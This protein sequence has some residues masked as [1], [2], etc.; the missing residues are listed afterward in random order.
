[1]SSNKFSETIYVST[2]P[3]AADKCSVFPDD[4]NDCGWY[5]IYE[6]TCEGRGCCYDDTNYYETNIINC[7]YPTG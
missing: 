6:E 3:I 7:F 1:M 5:G 4:R 2:F